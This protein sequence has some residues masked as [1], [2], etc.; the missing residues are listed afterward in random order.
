MYSVFIYVFLSS[1][2]LFFSPFF[3]IFLYIFGKSVSETIIFVREITE[4]SKGKTSQI[5][6][7]IKV[8]FKFTESREM[9]VATGIIRDP[10]LISNTICINVLLGSIDDFK[11]ISINK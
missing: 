10:Y 4:K 5:A 9:I 11:S 7:G 3:N 8:S 2:P 6:F 1:P